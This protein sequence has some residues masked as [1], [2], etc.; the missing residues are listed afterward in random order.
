M[1][2][3]ILVGMQIIEILEPA[4]LLCSTPTLLVSQREGI[5]I[6]NFDTF[7]TSKVHGPVFQNYF[8]VS[9]EESSFQ[10]RKFQISV[11]TVIP[12]GCTKQFCILQSPISYCVSLIIMVTITRHIFVTISQTEHFSAV[13]FAIGYKKNMNFFMIAKSLKV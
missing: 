7:M 9:F 1:Q 13:K 12:F 11:E 4:N 6:D 8:F 5:N 2:N 10:R 3:Y